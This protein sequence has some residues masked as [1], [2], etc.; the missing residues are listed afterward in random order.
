MSHFKFFKIF[1]NVMGYEAIIFVCPEYFPSIALILIAV[2]LLWPK[3][4]DMWAMSDCRGDAHMNQEDAVR[5]LSDV[6][7]IEMTLFSCFL[8][9]Q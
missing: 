7:I 9:S 3:T 1:F 8:L 4:M 6:Q 2:G 5:I